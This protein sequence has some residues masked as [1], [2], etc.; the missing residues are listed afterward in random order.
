MKR[1]SSVC[2]LALIVG[3]CGGDGTNP[4]T[5]SFD[6]NDP[7]TT[8][9]PDS[10]TEVSAAGIPVLIASDLDSLSYNATDKTLTVTGLTQDGTSAVNAYRHVVDGQ[11]TITTSDGNTY[12]AFVNGYTTFTRQNDAL[13]RH[14]TAFVASRAG[15]QAGVVMTGGQFNKFFAGTYYERNGDYVAPTAPDTRFDVTYHGTYAAGIN[16]S[17]PNTDLLPIVGPIDEDIDVPRQSAYV[18]GL[19]FV[20]VD[21]NDMSVEGQIYNRTGVFRADE[22]AD[23]TVGFF[24]YPEITLVEGVLAAD[25][26]F[27]GKVQ[28]QGKLLDIGDFA[29]I[30]GGDSGQALAGGTRFEDFETTFEDEIEYGVFVLDICEVGDTG[31][32]C[33]NALP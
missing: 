4:F 5:T 16:F 23:D 30:I 21:L 14:S 1:F 15:L 3:A 11:Q 10:E 8:I 28:N 32:I 31:D 33:T 26:S 7:A 6:A 29:G 25:G 12:S 17:G 2:A 18:R 19:I 20:N 22:T 13:G 9:D 27:A 24:G